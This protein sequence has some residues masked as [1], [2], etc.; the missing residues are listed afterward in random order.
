MDRA[1]FFEKYDIDPYAFLGVETLC[2]DKEVIKKAYKKK[3][4]VYHPDKT[5]GKTDVQF[6]IL[7]KCY[8]YAVKNIIKKSKNHEE[9]KNESKRFED[10][11][12]TL[13]TLDT[14]RGP[15]NNLGMFDTDRDKLFVDDDLD[16]NFDEKIKECNSRDIN[17]TNIEVYDNKFR[18]KM[19]DDGGKLNREKFNAV[20]LHLKRENERKNPDQIIKHPGVLACNQ[21]DIESCFT[22]VHIHENQV[23]NSV[24][25][26]SPDSFKKIKHKLKQSDIDEALRMDLKKINK[27]IKESK[28]DTGKMSRKKFNSE[29]INKKSAK[30][31]VTS[32][33]KSFA[34][35]EEEMKRKHLEQLVKESEMQKEFVLKKNKIYRFIQ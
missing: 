10:T 6:K 25:K 3:A 35:M 13:D 16:P 24:K 28:K 27:L 2:Q 14:P 15:R 22:N 11:L 32:C 18:D 31:P 29:L 19:C 9:L 7:N 8:K 1:N 17:Y 5:N 26:D 12:D 33:G 30:I 21:E 20:F 34:E 4:L 23:L